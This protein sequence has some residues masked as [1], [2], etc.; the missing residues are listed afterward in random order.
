MDNDPT[1]T[2]SRLNDCATS[3]ERWFMFNDLKL[4]PSKSEALIVGSRHQMKSVQYDSD[5]VEISGV[6]V[7]FSAHVKLLGVTFDSILSFDRHTSDICSNAFFHLKAL[8]HIR[9]KLDRSTAN[10][11]A[12][13]FV[14]SRFDYCNAI[15]AD[16][17]CS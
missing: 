10:F 17:V 7:P 11:I 8:R 9:S 6:T 3:V 4:N 12:Y 5:S 1:A 13:S 15:L 16:I 2:K 14:A